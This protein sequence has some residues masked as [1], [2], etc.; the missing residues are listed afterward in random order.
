MNDHDGTRVLR[1]EPLEKRSL[2]AGNLFGG[3]DLRINLFGHDKRGD[4][5]SRIL[6]S[7]RSQQVAANIPNNRQPTRIVADATT[8]PPRQDSPAG[9]S[10]FVVVEAA[11]LSATTVPDVEQRRSQAPAD[12]VIDTAI[13]AFTTDEVTEAADGIVE[14]D[15]LLREE[16]QESH[17]AP[18][19]TSGTL[20]DLRS[21]LSRIQV[22]P[23]ERD[24]GL[25]E[26]SPLEFDLSEDG[27]RDKSEPW[28]IGA[29]ILPK[30]RSALEQT[31]DLH[32]QVVDAAIASWFGGN[33]G[34]GG[35][36]AVDQF[37]LPQ[38]VF[39]TAIEWIEVALQSDL[40]LHR[41][42]GMIAGG[43]TPPISDVTLDAI[44]ASLAEIA[45]SQTQP[46]SSIH[47]FEVPTVAY[48]AIAI[49]TTVA[50]AA[51]RKRYK[52]KGEGIGDLPVRV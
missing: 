24:G 3:D 48:P 11:P 20:T 12:A 27:S 45:D 50:I 36:I 7:D 23:I 39:D 14:D 42:L 15:L 6:D 35:M 32:G 5:Q 26:L 47:R 44:M 49:L 13:A 25:I 9:P 16:R 33:A 4:D 31:T 22:A 41:S 17:S 18:I 29:D 37:I 52:G 19:A 30:I 40:K 10:L 1:I 43:S 34:S 21:G 38:T 2:L 28:Q 51:R 8:I 46:I